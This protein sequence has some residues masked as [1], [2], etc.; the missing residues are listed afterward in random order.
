[1]PDPQP[2]PPRISTGRLPALFFGTGAL[3]FALALADRAVILAGIFSATL[4]TAFMA[5]LL[6]FLTAPAVAFLQARLR[7]PKTAAVASV[8]LVILAALA[9]LAAATA[10]V[11]IPEAADLAGRGSQV[12]GRVT[13]MLAGLQSALGI[14]PHV[15]NL[16]SVF[17]SVQA[18][19]PSLS[20][21]VVAAEIAGAAGGILAAMGALL[22][23]VILS[24]YA[25][26]DSDG[27][28]NGLR[29]AVPNR[30][31]GELALVQASVGRSFSG[32][33]RTQAVLAV[34]Q[35]ALTLIAGTVFGLP[36]LYLATM[37]GAMA[38][39][40]PFFG[41]PLALLPPV[42]IAVLFRPDVALP[43]VLAI[44][45][46]QTVLVNVLQ[47]RLMREHLGIHP[48]LVLLALLVGS[49]IAG[50]WGALLAVPLSAA[51][52]LMAHYAIDRR[53]VNEVEGIDLDTV[54]A[55]ISAADP[56]LP[57]FEVVAI[58]A[59][60]AEAISAEADSSGPQAPD[61]DAAAAQ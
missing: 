22:T 35:A 29:R 24:L 17:K 44:V 57:L 61:A 19:F 36:Y 7:L 58:A 49:Q 56:D 1:M 55:E 37:S 34:L 10:A 18:S 60:R 23:V 27:I 30:Y 6:A 46:V 51:A 4:L 45:I 42:A 43:A 48:I 31:A 50:I 5:G 54:V 21:P 25:A 12:T 11:G 53:A 40:I 13:A 41:P 16:V 47:P 52:S 3:F 38:M 26:L 20:G 33:L 14:D 8:Y 28:L 59:D 32:F 2:Q 39:F 9:G 15:F